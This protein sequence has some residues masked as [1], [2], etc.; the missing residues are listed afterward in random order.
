WI[1]AIALFSLAGIPPTAG[2]FGKMFLITSGTVKNNYGIIVFAAFNMVLSLFYYLK[3]IK[4]VFID[5][6]EHPI[7]KLKINTIERLGLFICLSGIIVAGIIS[8]LY[9]Y[10]YNLLSF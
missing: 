2:F 7:Q 4:T 9:E 1:L 3:I 8:N 10:I 6:N 5:K